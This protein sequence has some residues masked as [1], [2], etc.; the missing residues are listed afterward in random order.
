MARW[1]TSPASRALL[2]F[3]H[4]RRDSLCY[5]LASGLADSLRA[6]GLEPVVADLYA[7]QFDPVAAEPATAEQARVAAAALLVF[8]YPVWWWSPPAMLKGWCDRVLTSGFAFR[9]SAS[10][11]R[12]EGQLGGR[13]GAVVTTSTV[14][15]RSYE[16]EWQRG[17]HVDFVPSILR[18]SGVEPVDELHLDGVHRYSDP[19]RL[20]ENLRAVEAFGERLACRR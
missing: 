15:P 14:A 10:E 12:Y 2:V 4:P 13:Q 16:V 7:E 20:R 18:M 19:E 8:V 11:N 9:F 3:A 17:A 6:G 1:S 5:A